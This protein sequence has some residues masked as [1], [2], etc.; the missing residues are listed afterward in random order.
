MI[1]PIDRQRMANASKIF[2][3][4]DAEHFSLPASLSE[5]RDVHRRL[6]EAHS[7]ASAEYERL[8]RAGVTGELAGDVL[9]AAEAGKAWPDPGPRALEA[10]EAIAAAR[11]R[12]DVLAEAST[13]AMRSLVYGSHFE[14]L[15]EG[16]LRPA[17]A[18]VVAAVQAL[19]PALEGRNVESPEN[20]MKAPDS[21]RVAYNQLTD[22]DFRYRSIRSAQAAASRLLGGAQIDTASKFAEL[23]DPEAVGV[24]ISSGNAREVSMPIPEHRLAKLVWI[25]TTAKDEVWVPLPHEMD[26]QAAGYFKAAADRRFAGHPGL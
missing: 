12:L 23:R 15:I 16:H 19:V 1:D 8:R 18:E 2:D 26:E 9:K 25:A 7:T 20:F 3:F 24:P 17:L 10:E 5:A 21:A 6:Q 14:E 11:L 4:A 22:L 13:A